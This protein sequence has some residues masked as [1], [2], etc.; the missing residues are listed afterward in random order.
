LTDGGNNEARAAWYLTPLNIQS[1]STDFEFQITPGTAKA[2][3]G[4]TFTIQ[5]VGP[6]ARGGI[7]GALGYQGIKSSVAVKF[8]T[9]SNAGEGVNSTGFYTNGVAPTIPAMDLTSSGVNLHSGDVMHAHL[10]YDGTMLT[11]ALTDTVTN[12]TF[13]AS[14]AINIPA[15][16]GANTAFVGFTGGTGGTVSTQNILNWVYTPGASTPPVSTPVTAIPAFSPASGIYTVPQSV[17]ITD[18]TPGA[19][20]YYTTNGTKPT[21]ASSAYTGPIS[22]GASETLQAIAV[23]SGFTTSAVSTAAYT[24]N[25]GSSQPTVNYPTGFASVANFALIGGPTFAAGAMQVTDGG[26]NEAHAV[27][28]STPV[29][30]QHFATDF[31]FQ[32]TPATARASDGMTFTI[33]NVGLTAHG[34]IGGALGYQGIKS[35]VAVKFDTF[36]NA[37]E[38]VN[39]TGFY[40]NG[41]APTIP[42]LDLTPSGIDLHSGDVMHAHLTY[43]GTT[44]TLTLTDTATNATFTASQAIN[45]PA[46]VGATTAFVGFTGG[47]GGTVSTQDVLTWT[48]SAN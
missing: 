31:T 28:Y 44:L 35:S 9:F 8:D 24:I 15:A 11:L 38:G 17:T 29:N 3:D 4:M 2:S 48:Y 42:A 12:A 22:V 32:I 26:N 13:T 37:G 10:T 16:V 46:T 20:I 39:S 14:Q 27:W 23:A 34:G 47:T 5:N 18:A 6:A 7:G 30:I 19:T 43:D 21:T 40:I 1:F 45:I 36:S 25:T 41:V 33:Q